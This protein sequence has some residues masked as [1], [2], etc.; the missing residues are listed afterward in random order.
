MKF[1]SSRLQFWDLLMCAN[2]GLVFYHQKYLS[3]REFGRS[4]GEV[5]TGTVKTDQL[6]TNKKTQSGADRTNGSC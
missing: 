5:F 3:A 6:P 2:Y 1:N 4:H